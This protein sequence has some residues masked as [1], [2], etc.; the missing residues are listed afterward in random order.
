MPVSTEVVDL[1]VVATRRLSPSIVRVELRGA[2]PSL[3]VP[4]E[5]CVLQFP[6]PGGKEPVEGSGRWYTVRRIDG[7]GLTVDIVVHPGGSGGGWAAVGRAGDRLRRTHG[8]SW[9]RRPEGVAWQ[10]LAGDVTAL[11]AIGRIVE[12]SAGDVRTIVHVE[13]PDPADAQDLPGAEV[14]WHHTPG[15]AR[16][17]RVSLTPGS[18]GIRLR[19][20]PLGLP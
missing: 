12:E 15:P 9:F 8:N 16:G 2:V 19:A 13:I 5:A 4:D 14:T 11:P 20:Q 18:E 6:E 3:G 10:L 1:D 7:A 17:S